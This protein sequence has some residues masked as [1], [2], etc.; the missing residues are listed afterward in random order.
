MKGL[1][2]LALVG[3]AFASSGSDSSC[4]C[5]PHQSCWP[6]EQEWSALNSSVQGNLQA[7]QPVAATCH[8]G[9]KKACAAITQ[10]WTNSTW[11]TTQP[12]AVQWEN[13]ETRPEL[14][15]SR[16]LETPKATCGQGRISLY[17][18]LA[19]SAPT[20]KQQFDL[21]ILV[22]EHYIHRRV[23][24]RGNSKERGPAVTIGAG[25]NLI[26]LYAAVGKKGRTV[27]A[28]TSHTVGAAGGYIQGGG[29]SLMGPWKGMAADNV[30]E[31]QVV[32]AN[33]TL[34]TANSHQNP[35]LFWALRGGGG[36]TFGVIV[37][38]TL[39]TFDEAP[40]TMVNLNVS[41]VAQNP[42]FWGAMTDFHPAI[43]SLND[44]GASGYYFISPNVPFKNMEVSRLSILLFSPNQT[45]VAKTDKLV[46][47]LQ[48]KLNGT[49]GLITEY[50]TIPFPTIHSLLSGLLIRGNMDPTGQSVILGSRLFSLAGGAIAKNAESVDNG[51]NP[52]WRKAAT[53]MY[54][55]RYWAP[56]ATLAQQQDVIRN[57][58]EVGMP[59]LKD[60]EGCKMGA[61]LNEA[62]AYEPDFQNEFWGS[63]YPR[64]YEIKQKWDPNGLFIARKGVGS[65][66][67]DDA[68]LCRIKKK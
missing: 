61:Y 62:N 28:G 47:P 22:E 9:N 44:A 58:A 46:A 42:G 48:W 25:I 7:T 38:A 4:R 41:T 6:V 17:S 19:K 23:Q 60:V 43:P 53:H 45:N 5:R 2:N 26:E 33:G 16:R 27:V 36:G 32:T 66:D 11:R 12:G 1:L 21:H 49:V 15:E 39:R 34:V 63:N 52:A 18:V 51:I 20:S 67:W 40:V 68:R 64:L 65:E 13:W 24:A 29:H 59:I 55:A 50:A 31:F 37:S 54:F 30:L 3:L 56:N 35:D 14:N 10:Q 8:E 57:M